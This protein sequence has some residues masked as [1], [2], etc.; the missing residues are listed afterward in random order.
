M[1]EETIIKR[2]KCCGTPKISHSVY[3]RFGKMWTKCN[4][5]N[6]KKKRED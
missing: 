6:S 1:K 3:K 4:G 2:C 5:C